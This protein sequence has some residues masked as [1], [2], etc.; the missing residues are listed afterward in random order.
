MNRSNFLKTTQILCALFALCF[1]ICSCGDNS[2]CTDPNA[3][4]YDPEAVEDNGNCQDQDTWYQ[5]Q[6]KDGLGDPNSTTLSC[7]QP[8]GYVSNS[9]DDYDLVVSDTQRAIVTYFGATWCPPCGENG[10]P[11]ID[12]TS[13]NVSTDRAVV[14]SFQVSDRI[15][16]INTPPT[17]FANEISDITGSSSLPHIYIGGGNIFEDRGLYTDAN[18]NE[19]VLENNIDNITEQTTKVGVAGNA[20]LENDKVEVNLGVEFFAASTEAFYISTFLLE[21][22]VIADQKV[23]TVANPMD[24]EDVPHDGVVRANFDGATSFRGMELGTSFTAGQVLSQS[25]TISLPEIPEP[26]PQ[27]NL[28]NIKLAVVVFRGSGYDLEN[29]VMIDI[30]Q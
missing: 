22:Q 28:E 8:E 12:Y 4:N 13:E 14:M 27:M 2:G 17:E 19:L 29:G 16:Q 11:L 25:F 18:L 30:Q 6:D 9:D 10:G 24:A 7:T 15:S 3:C 5:D 26:S 21:D 23:G 1:F 20:R